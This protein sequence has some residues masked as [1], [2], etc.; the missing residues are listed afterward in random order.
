MFYIRQCRKCNKIKE[1]T[2][3]PTH[4]D[5]RPRYTCKDCTKI[6]NRQSNARRKSLNPELYKIQRN[7]SNKKYL[8]TKPFRRWAQVTIHS[9]R[10]RGFEVNITIPSLANKA[11]ITTHCLYCGSTLDFNRYIDKKSYNRPTLDRINNENIMTLENTQIICLTCNLAKGQ[12]TH[13]E[14][15]NHCKSIARRF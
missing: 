4:K 15:I 1:D 6:V 5:G 2:E 10:K 3:F 9:H 8:T 11:K 13:N 14:F 12:M 7:N